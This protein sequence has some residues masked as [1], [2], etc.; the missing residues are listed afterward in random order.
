MAA[1]IYRPAKTAMQSGKAKTH[2]WVLEFD[3]EQPRRIDPILG[4]T[5]SGDMKQQLRLTFESQEQAEAYAKRE[6]IEYRVIQPKDPN[7]QIVS[8]TDNFRFSRTQPWTH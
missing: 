3:Q 1:K 6:G 4:Y 5:S 2:L 7:R 8:Y